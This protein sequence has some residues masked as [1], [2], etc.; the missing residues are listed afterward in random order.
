MSGFQCLL[1]IIILK[2]DRK[3]YSDNL[4]L[5]IF[6]FKVADNIHFEYNLQLLTATDLRFIDAGESDFKKMSKTVHS[7]QFVFQSAKYTNIRRPK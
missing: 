1:S 4:F 2:P 3:I 7:Y 5:S 6:L